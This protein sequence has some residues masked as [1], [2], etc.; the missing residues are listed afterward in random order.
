VLPYR[1]GHSAY[2]AAC[3]PHDTHLCFDISRIDITLVDSN[4]QIGAELFSSPK[5]ASVYPSLCP[6]PLRSQ[7]RTGNSAAKFGSIESAPSCLLPRLLQSAER[8]DQSRPNSAVTGSDSQ[9]PCS[10]PCVDSLAPYGLDL[11]YLHFQAC[12]LSGQW[13]DA[14][15]LADGFPL[16]RAEAAIRADTRRFYKPST[17]RPAAI[18]LAQN[19]YEIARGSGGWPRQARPRMQCRSGGQLRVGLPSCVSVTGMLR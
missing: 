17:L 15:R 8:G 10:S 18:A 5:T 19:V 2:K 7:E 14:Q 3:H 13:D 1:L 6:R 11:R 12:F 16:S 4:R 9:S